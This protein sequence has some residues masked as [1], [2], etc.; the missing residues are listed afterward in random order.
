[1]INLAFRFIKLTFELA[2]NVWKFYQNLRYTRH[3]KVSKNIHWIN[4]LTNWI[5]NHIVFQNWIKNN[6]LNQPNF[7]TGRRV[8]RSS[9]SISPSSLS[10]FG[11]SIRFRFCRVNRYFGWINESTNGNLRIKFRHQKAMLFMLIGRYYRSWMAENRPQAGSNS[12]SIP[13]WAI[14]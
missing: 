2:S 6:K 7:Y 5:K 1:V 11:S 13:A 8:C 10:L 14:Y 12:D 9:S 3:T 4:S